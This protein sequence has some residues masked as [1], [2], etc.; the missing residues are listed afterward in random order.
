M[1]KKASAETTV[2][3]IRRK[4]R[5]QFSAEERIRIVLEGLRVDLILKN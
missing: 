1:K 2:R 5:R 4:N 3:N